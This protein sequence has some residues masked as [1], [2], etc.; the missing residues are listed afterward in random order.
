LSS[1]N[2]LSREIYSIS[3][4]FAGKFHFSES[5]HQT[6]NTAL[7]RQIQSRKARRFQ[8]RFFTKFKLENMATSLKSRWF[9]FYIDKKKWEKNLKS[10]VFDEILNKVWAEFTN[11]VKLTESDA[12]MTHS[13]MMYWVQLHLKQQIKAKGLESTYKNKFGQP[14][15]AAEKGVNLTFSVLFR[16]M[17][18]LIVNSLQDKW[19]FADGMSEQKIFEFIRKF[20]GT[21]WFMGDTTE[22]DASQSWITNFFLRTIWSVFCPNVKYEE[23]YPMV[24]EFR[25][26]FSKFFTAPGESSRQSGFPDTMFGNIMFTM[27]FICTMFNPE[28]VACG[29][30]KGD[31]L[32]LLLT[33]LAAANTSF[34]DK[35][36]LNPLKIIV[37][38]NCMEFCN[39]LFSKTAYCYNPHILLMKIMN[40]R[41]ELVLK[42]KNSWNEYRDSL[43]VVIAPYLMRP[44]EC[45]Q[46]CSEWTGRHKAYYE[47]LWKVLDSFSQISYASAKELY[48]L[49]TLNEYGGGVTQTIPSQL[50][51]TPTNEMSDVKLEVK[52]TNANKQNQRKQ[53]NANRK[54]RNNQ[55]QA[56]GPQQ[57][58]KQNRGRPQRVNFKPNSFKPKPQKDNTID[59]FLQYVTMPSLA[60]CV[61][62]G[63][64]TSNEP[65]AVAAPYYRFDLP[66]DSNN[67]VVHQFRDPL[68]SFVFKDSTIASASYVAYM[69]DPQGDDTTPI[70]PDTEITMRF[71]NAQKT[72]INIAYMSASGTVDERPHGD[73]LYIGKTDRLN[74]ACFIW[75]DAGTHIVMEGT[76]SLS[77]ALVFGL[78][79]F[80][81]RGQIH[82]SEYTDE[83]SGTAPAF[84]ITVTDSGY[85]APY[86]ATSNTSNLAA[87]ITITSLSISKSTPGFMC[88]YAMPQFDQNYQRFDSVRIIAVEGLYTNNS[89]NIDK[90]GKIA[91]WQVPRGSSWTDY[92]TYQSVASVRTSDVVPAVTGAHNFLKPAQ[93]SDFAWQTP[94]ESNE[95][96]LYN[97][98][99]SLLSNYDF[100]STAFAINASDARAFYVTLCW[101]IEMRT[102]DLYADLAISHMSSLQLMGAL[103]RLKR[104]KQYAS[105]AKHI[106]ELMGS[107]WKGVKTWVPRIGQALKDH[108]PMLAE[109]ASTLL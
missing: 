10:E 21:H 2:L 44:N 5:F 24:S 9:K 91:Q 41:A 8:E 104:T 103:E 14:I 54:P 45:N 33:R 62:I 52:T 92:Q 87:N 60:S 89:A 18:V 30:F 4:A 71:M 76:S 75:M 67:Y 82:E 102:G 97:S 39:F 90:Q 70:A 1:I 63:D 73:T 105:N 81:S 47:Y 106:K 50:P 109:L 35:I 32:S 49:V 46:L 100:I 51:S 20:S 83:I 107:I 29:V 27:L 64:E 96:V 31:D 58:P 17:R 43:S 15:A 99:F 94:V 37:N 23:L 93:E 16:L 72:H 108:G 12:K 56:K 84:D 36:F 101:G 7:G 3:S 48:Q 66:I 19:C 79:S 95:T 57:R 88:H 61:R 26:V 13:K 28:D 25:P 42:D 53:Q 40:K 86:L 68:R 11:V 34:F 74:P 22:M 69:N 59:N 77:T 78:D 6:T 38:K 55:K 65:T 98:W 85:Y 80:A